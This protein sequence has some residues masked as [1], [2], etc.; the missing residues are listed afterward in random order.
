MITPAGKE[1]RHF[2]GD[3]FRGR[4]IER[5]RLL[6]ANKLNW[7]PNLCNTCPVPEILQA[8]ACEHQT[9]V[10]SLE[11]PLF[12]MRPEVRLKAECSKCACMVDEPAIGC[13]QCV[14]LPGVWVV[15][16]TKES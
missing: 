13:G 4:N 9:L 12:F 14:V 5:C 8:N 3:Y 7:T 2:F 6:E 11:K 1:C 10:P 15:A 16:P